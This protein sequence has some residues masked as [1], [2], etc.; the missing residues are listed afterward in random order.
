MLD[1]PSVSGEFAWKE[2][3]I[4]FRQTHQKTAKL[5]GLSSCLQKTKLFAKKLSSNNLYVSLM[6]LSGFGRKNRI[7]RYSW[8]AYDHEGIDLSQSRVFLCHTDKEPSR[9]LTSR[10]I[11]VSVCFVC[12]FLAWKRF[13]VS[14]LIPAKPYTIFFVLINNELQ[15]DQTTFCLFDIQ[16][17]AIPDPRGGTCLCNYERLPVVSA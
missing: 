17:E 7:I 9:P 8:L 16:L 4:V 2:I 3:T 15:R 1:F 13:Q 11:Q 6:T 12:G 10:E 14:V 5:F